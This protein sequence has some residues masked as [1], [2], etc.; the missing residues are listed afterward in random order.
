M[1]WQKE[2]YPE[3]WPEIERACKDRA[4]WIC[5]WCSVDHGTMRIGKKY[6]RPYKVILSGAH[7]NHDPSDNRD[8]NLIALCQE[9]HL[10]HDRWQ[11]VESCRRTKQ[12]KRREA[13]LEAGQLR[14]LQEGNEDK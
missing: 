6:K 13:Q 8:E 1:P 3:N 7:L 5:E 14:L 2:L 4:G 11:H 9:C 10:C 12:R